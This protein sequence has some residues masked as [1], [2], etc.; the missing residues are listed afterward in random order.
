LE[1]IRGIFLSDHCPSLTGVGVILP[2]R[3]LCAP[4]SSEYS[5]REVK[6]D[7]ESKLVQIAL[8]GYVGEIG[9]SRDIPWGYGFHDSCWRLLLARLSQFDQTDIVN[10][11]F[12]FLYHTPLSCFQ[13]PGRSE[14]LSHGFADPC[15]IPSLRELERFAQ[16]P[17][18]ASKKTVDICSNSP[19]GLGSAFGILPLE[20]IYLILSY[21]SLSQVAQ[22][23]LVCRELAQVAKLDNLSP[24]F[25]K[26]RFRHGYE[27]AYLCADLS[28]K[29][30]WRQLF[31]GANTCLKQ[32]MLRLINRKR[33]WAL[34]EPIAVLMEEAESTKLQGLPVSLAD[35]D[36][37]RYQLLRNKSPDLPATFT[38]IRSFSGQLPPDGY[39]GYLLDGCRVQQ[40]RV[41]QFPSQFSEDGGKV[42][43]STVRV[44]VQ[45]YISGI[46]ISS[47]L[48]SDLSQIGLYDP[49]QEKS[50]EIPPF[51][52]VKI[53]EVAF[54]R[55][56]LV[57]IRFLFTGYHSSEWVGQAD[58]E[59][60]GRGILSPPEDTDA[61]YLVAGVDVCPLSSFSL[62]CH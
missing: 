16:M 42:G 58:G 19:E 28:I 33:I 27:Q 29:R 30:N 61:H 40:Y 24:S 54:C 26:S 35:T 43:V 23:R 22:V 41:A 31:L 12:T 8:L 52:R 50:I 57:G 46:K 56:G 51:A 45:R 48:P 39:S 20:L 59:G 5:F 34:L 1:E 13:Y 62:P 7:A 32:G 18:P 14:L 37:G 15:A 53:I 49:S 60:I 38:T 44:G 10:F 4:V 17:S 11:V 9:R 36:K 55:S 21:L 6:D 3:V 25:W 2:M 47:L